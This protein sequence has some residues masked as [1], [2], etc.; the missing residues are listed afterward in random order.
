MTSAENECKRVNKRARLQLCAKSENWVHGRCTKRVTTKLATRFV[1]SRCSDMMEKM[2]KSIEELCDEVEMVNGFCY[3]G[4][5]LNASGVCK[6][7][8]TTRV[9]IGW[10]RFRKRGVVLKISFR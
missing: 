8:V 10:V 1:G 5:K 4:D 9:R 7:A 2:V 3:Q 6:A